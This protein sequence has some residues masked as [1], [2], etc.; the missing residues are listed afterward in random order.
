MRKYLVFLLLSCFAISC[1]QQENIN[2]LI[3]KAEQGDVEAQFNLGYYYHSG[4]GVEKSEKKALYWWQKAAKQG[5]ANSQYNLGVNYGKGYGV[6]QSYKKAI[7]WWQK[8]AEQGH[9]EAQFNL[10]VVHEKG[11]G[12]E[13]SYEK[14]IHWYTKAA[15]QGFVRAQNNL[16]LVIMMEMAW[17]NPI[18]T[19][20]IGLLKLWNKDLQS[21]N[22][23]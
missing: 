14:A 16:G 15:E 13:Q 2:D 5:H 20:Y 21:L 4:E 6:E 11:Y 7:Y 12:V 10:G 17:N 18:P 19:Q 23:I 3:K 9:A 8:A 1:T 22:I